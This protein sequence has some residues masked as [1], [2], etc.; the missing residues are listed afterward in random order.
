MRIN[1][2][3][4]FTKKGMFIFFLSYFFGDFTQLWVSWHKKL[5]ENFIINDKS[6]N[7]KKL[8]PLKLMY[9]KLFS[10]NSKLYKILIRESI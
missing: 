10:E 8:K 3:K 4:N 1:I 5:Y 9:L 7:Y 6:N 2:G